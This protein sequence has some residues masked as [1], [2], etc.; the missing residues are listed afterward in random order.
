M[1]GSPC[2]TIVRR[3]DA[4]SSLW[5]DLVREA[6]PFFNYFWISLENKDLEVKKV[7]FFSVNIRHN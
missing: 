7:L 5:R 1:W 2:S 4:T 6:R 3:V